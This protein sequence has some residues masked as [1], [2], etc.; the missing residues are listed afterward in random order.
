MSQKKIATN[1]LKLLVING[2]FRESSLSGTFAQLFGRMAQST[3][4]ICH[5]GVRELNLPNFDYE[6]AKHPQAQKFRAAIAKAD[7]IILISPEYHGCVSGALKNSLDYI[8]HE[9]A[10]KPVGVLATAGSAKSGT[11]TLN[12]LRTICRSLRSHVLIEQISLSKEELTSDKQLNEK[13]RERCEGM[14]NEMLDTIYRLN[15]YSET[16]ETQRFA[17]A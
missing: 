14:I 5:L 16:K 17:L 7:G 15:T 2:S 3:F 4:D 11:N 10:N 6:V 12:T 13:T 8:Q 1:P 9:L